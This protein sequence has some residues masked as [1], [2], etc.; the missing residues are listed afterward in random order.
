MDI[1]KARDSLL[2]ISLSKLDFQPFAPIL[3]KIHTMARPHF[4]AMMNQLARYLDAGEVYLEVG[5]YQGGSLISTLLNNQA[6]AISVD[7]FS[8]FRDTNNFKILTQHASDFGMSDRIT[9]YNMDFH[10]YF[11][12]NVPAIGMYY[13][14]GAHDALNT[15]EGLELGFP[16]VVKDG[17]II[18]DDTLYPDVVL[19]LN[20]FLGVHAADVKILYAAS[21]ALEFHPGWWNGTIVLQKTNGGLI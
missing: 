7:N 14:D 16:F 8:E 17:L 15:Q 19:G 11:M 9:F 2:P 18:L 6:S 4:L 10:D 1:Q 5:S 12:G 21:P 20:R 13:Y 3:E